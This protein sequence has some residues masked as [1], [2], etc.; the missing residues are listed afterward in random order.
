MVLGDPAYPVL[1]WLMVGYKPY[2][3]ENE[4]SFN[5]Y[6]SSARLVVEIA[7]GRLKSRWRMLSKKI[8]VHHKRVPN[9]V[10]TC[11]VLHNFCEMEKETF[12][13]RWLQ[14]IEGNNLAYP[15]P[16]QR[17]SRRG[18]EQASSIQDHLCQYLSK[19]QE[20]KKSSYY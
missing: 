19:T 5:V 17:P 1:P 12:N 4:E 16:E 6:L 13:S 10:A 14:D 3:D 15:Q 20:L 8:D 7:F 18:N 9:I 11:V 2:K